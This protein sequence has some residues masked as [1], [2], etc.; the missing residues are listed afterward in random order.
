MSLLLPSQVC[1]GVRYIVAEDYSL[2]LL[3]CLKLRST[4]K[5]LERD[6]FFVKKNFSGSVWNVFITINISYSLFNVQP[7]ER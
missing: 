7:Y 4:I 6:V 3:P 2:R 1:R 5:T